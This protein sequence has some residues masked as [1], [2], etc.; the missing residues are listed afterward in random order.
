M[1]TNEVD[2]RL[3]ADGLTTLR[4]PAPAGLSGKVLASVG[5]DAADEYV[6]DALPPEADRIGAIEDT[7]QKLLLKVSK[8]G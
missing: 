5:L 1:N 7:L 2:D 6:Q 3:I 4:Q 8:P